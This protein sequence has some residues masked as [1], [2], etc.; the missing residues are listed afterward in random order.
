MLLIHIRLWLAKPYCEN[1]DFALARFRVGVKMWHMHFLFLSPP[2]SPIPHIDGWWVSIFAPREMHACWWVSTS[3]DLQSC[4]LSVQL[5]LASRD[6]H[7]LS[8]LVKDVICIWTRLF[9]CLEAGT[10]HLARS[11]A[12]QFVSHNCT[13]NYSVQENVHVLLF[14]VVFCFYAYFFQ[15]TVIQESVAT[16]SKTDV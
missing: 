4:V 10:N 1:Y 8:V 14:Y 12:G 9:Y 7:C 13:E 3:S 5:P 15:F 2:F 6:R 16:V 11:H